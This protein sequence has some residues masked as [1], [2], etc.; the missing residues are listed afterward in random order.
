MTRSDAPTTGTVASRFAAA[1]VV[2]FTLGT[3]GI[4]TD[5][6]ARPGSNYR[7]QLT[8]IDG[9][10]NQSRPGRAVHI[11]PKAAVPPPAPPPLDQR[12]YLPISS[13]RGG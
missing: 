11:A 13:L 7:Y 5:T 10:G 9:E 4:F 12:R 3:S 6:T 1:S 2:T 8:T